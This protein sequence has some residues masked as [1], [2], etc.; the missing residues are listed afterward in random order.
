[1]NL[2]ELIRHP[3]LY[4][5][6]RAD[7]APQYDPRMNVRALLPADLDVHKLQQTIKWIVYTLLIINF[8]YYIYEDWTRAIHTL[9]AGGSFVDW[10][11]E[12]AA[13]IDEV[14]WF[15]LLAMFE[16]ETYVLEDET[17]TGRLGRS[18]HI[19]R[20]A[21][22]AM[23]AHAIYAYIVAVISLQPTIPVEGV[24]SLCDMV[25]NNV[26]Y[27]YNL[28]YTEVDEQS[29]SG[30]SVAS[31]FYW[32][33]DD[34]IVSDKVGLELERDLAWADLLEAVIWLVIV[35]AIEIVV[36][37]QGRGVTRGPVIATANVMQIVLYTTLIGI[38]IYWASLA[39]WLYFWDELVWIGGFAAIE[40]NISE[41][42]SELLGE[43]ETG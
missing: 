40:M 9:R 24:S 25:N 30:L 41:W 20:V 33:G 7:A 1:M 29:C 27:V 38:G 13:S 43:A 28:E 35:L 4:A 36:R 21:C 12:F 15:I 14:G 18:V 19:V 3:C 10:A 5:W 16:L 39:H 17:W 32:L 26:S 6:I 8:G 37:L 34:L 31:E 22:Y 2:R 23:I 11:G 42:R